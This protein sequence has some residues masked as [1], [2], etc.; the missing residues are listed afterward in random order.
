MT[1]HRHNNNNT[2]P[3]HHTSIWH[4]KRPAITAQ[5]WHNGPSA[6]LSLTQPTCDVWAQAEDL[7]VMWLRLHAIENQIPC[8]VITQEFGTANPTW[9]LLFY[10]QDKPIFCPTRI[11]ILQ[12]QTD[13]VISANNILEIIMTAFRTTLTRKFPPTAQPL[14]PENEYLFNF[15]HEKVSSRLNINTHIPAVPSSKDA[16]TVKLSDNL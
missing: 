3:H 4:L 14:H 1:Q 15:N 6:W 2:A 7:F 10:L 16:A 8:T 5:C 11:S 12:L 13:N 9:Q